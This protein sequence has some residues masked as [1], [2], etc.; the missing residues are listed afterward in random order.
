MIFS[1]ASASVPFDCPPPGRRAPSNAPLTM[2]VKIEATVDEHLHFENVS[3]IRR[4]P[5]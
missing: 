1:A 4:L 5:H 2:F 3:F